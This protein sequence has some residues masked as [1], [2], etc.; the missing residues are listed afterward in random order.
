MT[1][2]KGIERSD[3]PQFLREFSERNQDR[4]ARFEIFSRG[5]VSEEW[6]E[7]H[8]AGVGVKTDGASS[9][10]VV[11]RRMDKSGIEPREIVQAVPDVRRISVQYDTDNSEDA[12]EIEDARGAL[13][14]MRLES[15][16]DGAS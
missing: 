9:P 5:G 8:L 1:S 14:V 12:L 15:K 10:Q 13:L 7:G 4:R 11:V 2:I 16:V 3:W 6:E